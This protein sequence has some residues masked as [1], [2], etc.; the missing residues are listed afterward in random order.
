MDHH[1]PFYQKFPTWIAVSFLSGATVMIAAIAFTQPSSPAANS[2]LTYQAP[3]S[4]TAAADVSAPLS[5]AGTQVVI[6]QP[7]SGE[8]YAADAQV[9]I[10]A[11]AA[12]SQGV[13]DMTLWID[14]QLLKTCLTGQCAASVPA[15][16][17]SLRQ[18]HDIQ[19]LAT[20]LDGTPGSAASSFSVQ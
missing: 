9:N 8:S 15:S 17:L 14:G 13:K 3:S 19:V 11:L 10:S 20:G 7:A 18:S 16:S 5:G 2:S 4:P 6:I 12:N 1:K